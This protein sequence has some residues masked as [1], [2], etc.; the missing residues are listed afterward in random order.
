MINFL[1]VF[2]YKV[3]SAWT[4]SRKLSMRMLWPYILLV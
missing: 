2:L 3:T 1:L 4:L